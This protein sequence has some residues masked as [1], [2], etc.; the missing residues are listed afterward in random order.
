M[1]RIILHCLQ[2]AF[3][4]SPKSLGRL[5]LIHLVY[6]A[7]GFL[8]FAP[9]FAVL[10]RLILYFAGRPMIADVDILFFLTSPLGMASLILFGAMFIAV[11]IFEQ[12]SMMIVCAATTQKV[13]CSAKQAIYYSWKR[14]KAIFSFS[15][16]LIIRILLISLPFLFVAGVIAWLLMTK[17]DI[18][19]Y[20]S[21]KP[22][23]FV[24]AASLIA[25]ILLLMLIILMRKL[26]AWSLAFPLIMF[27]DTAPSASFS[28]S[29]N[30]SFGNRNSAFLLLI[31]WAFAALILGTMTLGAVQLLGTRLIS[32]FSNSLNLMVMALGG[33][34]ALLT[35]GNIL[36]STLASGCFASLLVVLFERLHGT[37][38][39]LGL[40]SAH[41]NWQLRIT[42]SRLMILLISGTIIS[43]AVGIWLLQGIQARD[44]V[45]IFAHR[46][47]AG[48][49]PE[50]TLAAIRQAITDGTDWVEIDVQETADGEIAVI[51]DSDLMKLAGVNLKVWESTL[52][53][54]R[55]VD[56]GSWFSH[57][58]SSERIPTLSEVLE[59]VRGKSRVLIEL[60]Y[61]GHDQ[62]LEKRVID[63]VE[64]QNMV[65]QIAIMSLK[66]DGIQKVRSLRPDWNIG[67]LSATAIGD[68]TRLNADFLAVNRGM[69][70]AAFIRSTKS[71]NKEVLVWT[72]NDPVSMSQ[73]ISLGVDGI[74]T[75]EPGLVRDVI[76][77]R[78]ELSSLERL[79]LH[80]AQLLGQPIP[81][82]QYRD[83]SP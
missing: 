69:A 58:F 5:F 21:V 54:L 71:V 42:F 10:I 57:K 19:Y 7:L 78:A 13:G 6:I 22:T 43:A 9:L 8:L 3:A 53:Q 68:M 56:V 32:F 37:P 67:L 51:H 23:E 83:Q 4:P 40:K 38:E 79:L 14:T 30:L 63:I 41:A 27:T 80:T 45:T 15:V 73:M 20:L 28:K 12:A 62:Q 24:L 75:D 70:N 16:R 55:E 46:G 49:A 64:Q 34:V 81:E 61:Y 65:D 31:L 11:L 72:V 26:V 17:Y 77:Q 25:F 39:L 36:V 35:F 33:I 48:K 76:A 29:E 44:D 59:E 60:K 52:A 1:A 47:A 66:Y 82:R 50:N 74:I 2:A 18:N